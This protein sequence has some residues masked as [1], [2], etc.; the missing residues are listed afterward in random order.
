MGEQEETKNKELQE[1]QDNF[2]QNFPAPLRVAPSP[3]ARLN[4][5][6]GHKTCEA[7]S[8]RV[9]SASFRKEP[10][11]ASCVEPMHYLSRT[12]CR[13][14]GLGPVV[15]Q[16]PPQCFK[17]LSLVALGRTKLGV[18]LAAAFAVKPWMWTAR[19]HEVREEFSFSE[20]T[21]ARSHTSDNGV[22]NGC[23]NMGSHMLSEHG[24]SYAAFPCVL[25]IQTLLVTS[26]V[27]KKAHR[28]IS[29][30]VTHHGCI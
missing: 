26:S 18:R 14:A 1:L 4:S 17:H 25:S 21:Q 3:Y 29:C 23:R 5:R 28:H 2:F 13:D 27:F 6:R 22:N 8:E 30:S 11:E 15:P 20:G 9:S 12:L 19:L 16:L 10:L 7:E 24:V